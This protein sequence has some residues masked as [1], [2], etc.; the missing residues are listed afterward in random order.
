LAADTAARA[1][2]NAR[3]ADGELISKKIN[4]L[5]E[6]FDGGVRGLNLEKELGKR[7]EHVI[8]S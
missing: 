8:L 6:S 1:I 5:C 4:A 3:K 2:A 7:R